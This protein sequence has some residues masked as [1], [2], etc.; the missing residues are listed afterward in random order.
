MSQVEDLKTIRDLT[1]QVVNFSEDPPDGIST[2][3]RDGQRN[4]PIGT[5]SRR[6]NLG[7]ATAHIYKHDA[8]KHD[9]KLEERSRGRKLIVA[10]LLNGNA[11][12]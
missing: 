4:P 1:H 2:A 5:S 3:E 6:K 12:A 7:E 8:W 10:T 11:S 9:Q